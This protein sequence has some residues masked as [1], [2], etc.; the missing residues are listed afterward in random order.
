MKEDL[1]FFYTEGVRAPFL[2]E[3]AGISYC[4]GSYYCERES[5]DVT[6]VEYVIRGRGTV[7]C[8]GR[9]YA[10]GEGDVYILHQGTGKFRVRGSF[11]AW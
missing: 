4:D 8:D 9:Q 10:P 3:L 1:R 5:S 11:L 2:V 6:V 7:L